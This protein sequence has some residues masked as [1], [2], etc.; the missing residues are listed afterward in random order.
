MRKIYGPNRTD[1][2]YCRIKINQE[3]NEKLKGQHINKFIKNQRLNWLG[4]VQRMAEDSNMQK[5][6][7]WKT[8]SE[9]PTG[10]PKTR[11]EDDFLKT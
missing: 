5:I 8:M 3:I 9:R 4:H 10:R 6:N 11:W 7:R 1:D 2:G